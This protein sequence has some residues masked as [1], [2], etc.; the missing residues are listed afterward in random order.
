VLQ[1]GGPAREESFRWLAQFRF[2]TRNLDGSLLR[3]GTWRHSKRGCLLAPMDS[4]P[5][6]GYGAVYVGIK[7]DLEW[8]VTNLGW[9]SYN[10][11]LPCGL[12]LADRAQRP[13]NDHRLHAA[14][15]ETVLTIE[16]YRAQYGGQGAHPLNE[17]DGTTPFTCYLDLLHI[18]DYKGISAHVAGSVIWGILCDRELAPNQ[19]T[20][21]REINRRLRDFYEQHHVRDR[22]RA[23]EVASSAPG[24]PGGRNPETPGLWGDNVWGEWFLLFI[25]GVRQRRAECN[26]EGGQ[27]LAG[28]RGEG[29]LK[30]ECFGGIEGWSLGFGRSCCPTLRVCIFVIPGA[31]LPDLRVSNIID[32]D[33]RAT[34]YAC[35]RGQVVKAAT[36]RAVVPFVRDLAVALDDGSPTRR[37]RRKACE[38]L[39][40]IYEVMDNASRF[41]TQAEKD[42]LS[43]SIQ[44]FLDHYMWLSCHS[45]RVGV[46]AWHYTPKHHYLLHVAFMAD[47]INPKCVQNYR[48]ESFVGVTTTLSAANANG[49]WERTIQ[50]RT[51]RKYLVGLQ[52]L[53]E[54]LE[55]PP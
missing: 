1:H 51:L 6:L 18:L 29:R 20:T 53:L 15:R 22:P 31:R 25:S 49:R 39:V 8:F 28:V 41:L 52:I 7:A 48:D 16:T 19:E 30:G 33:R 21:M 23:L 17:F 9:R 54:D 46:L 38:W 47:L 32:D 50:I 45:I 35:L 10:G 27:F 34:S 55:S 26:K 2:G 5:H 14:W 11:N 24:S 43:Y 4:Q 44:R 36:T 42:D 3:K 37:H 12:C 13:W 40:R